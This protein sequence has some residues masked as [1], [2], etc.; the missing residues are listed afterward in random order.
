MEYIFDELKQ[1][2]VK[3]VDDF[4]NKN[5]NYLLVYYGNEKISEKNIISII[6]ISN[7]LFY[8]RT[9]NCI[10]YT[11]KNLSYSSIFLNELFII[12]KKMNYDYIIS[13]KNHNLSDSNLNANVEVIQSFGKNNY[14]ITIKK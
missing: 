3:K 1:Y 12:D 11:D 9:N 14:K 6:I 8:Q 4:E 10:T 2:I 13:I 7:S 5:Y